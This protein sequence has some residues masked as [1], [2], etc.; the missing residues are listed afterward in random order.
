[1]RPLPY[2]D[3]LLEA[4]SPSEHGGGCLFAM[5]DGAKDPQ[6]HA[7]LTAAPNESDCLLR[8]RLPL[9]LRTVAAQLVALG[10][11]GERALDLIS[12]ARGF[13]V[14]ETPEQ[15]TWVLGTERDLR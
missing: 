6:V 15:R 5:V 8:G 12:D 3:R 2:E 10:E 7:E 13:R 9:A 1:M 14:P 11:P 4:L